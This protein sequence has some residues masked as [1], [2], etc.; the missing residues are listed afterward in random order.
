MPVP[1]VSRPPHVPNVQETAVCGVPLSITVFLVV[2]IPSTTSM[3]NAL[4]GYL[5]V[6]IV[7][8]TVATTRH[9]VTVKMILIVVGV[10]MSQIQVLVSVVKVA[11]LLPGTS[12][13]VWDTV[14]KKCMKGGFLRSVQVCLIDRN[15]LQY[16]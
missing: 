3:V 15:S 14:M 4:V 1:R 13:S 11:S 2:S 10:M 7:Q 6:P 16:K 8:A 9:V 5:M 12:A